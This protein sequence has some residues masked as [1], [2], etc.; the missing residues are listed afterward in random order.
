[1]AR[2]KLI[3]GQNLTFADYINVISLPFAEWQIWQM[4]QLSEAAD[5]ARTKSDQ[6]TMNDLGALQ[7]AY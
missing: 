2:K 6:P 4:S 3:N 5:S 7:K 1:M